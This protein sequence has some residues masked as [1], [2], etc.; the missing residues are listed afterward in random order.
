MCFFCLV[1][2]PGAQAFGTSCDQPG[3]RKLPKSALPQTFLIYKVHTILCSL[4]F[5]T[6]SK[7]LELKISLSMYCDKQDDDLTFGILVTLPACTFC[8]FKSKFVESH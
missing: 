4:L 3:I 1:E 7:C 8:T 6:N 5:S 2:S